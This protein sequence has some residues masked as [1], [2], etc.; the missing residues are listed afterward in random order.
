MNDI[1]I[2]I[3]FLNTNNRDIDKVVNMDIVL[4]KLVF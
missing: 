2:L 3:L 4:L 1:E